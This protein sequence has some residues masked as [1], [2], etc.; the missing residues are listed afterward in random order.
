MYSIEYILFPPTTKS[1]STCASPIVTKKI[2]RWPPPCPAC[3]THPDEHTSSHPWRPDPWYPLV[4]S[5]TE[6][7]PSS[8]WA[9]PSL[10]CTKAALT[11]PN[12]GNHPAACDVSKSLPCPQLC[13]QLPFPPHATPFPLSRTLPLT[14]LQCEILPPSPIQP[15]EL[16]SYTFSQ[17]NQTCPCEQRKST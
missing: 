16:P 14:L 4:P 1:L 10:S 3:L 5:R 17:D 12:K 8:S 11:S 15:T 2:M 7:S 6:S 9:Q 13:L